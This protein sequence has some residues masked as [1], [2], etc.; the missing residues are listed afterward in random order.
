M[1]KKKEAEQRNY[2]TY[3]KHFNK[4][5]GIAINRFEWVGLPK[6]IPEDFI[7]KTLIDKGKVV[8]VKDNMLDIMAYYVN[9]NGRINHYGYS[10]KITANGLEYN[11]PFKADEVV[12]CYN[13]KSKLGIRDVIEGECQRLAE[14]D[15]TIDTNIAGQ[16]TPFI[17]KCDDKTLLTLKIAYENIQT[18]T[19]VIFVDKNIN[20]SEVEVFQTPS[21]FVADKLVDIKHTIE[22][23]L[24]TMLGIDNTNID[25]KERVNTDE[26]K[27]NDEYIEN[28][29]QTMFSER[30]KCCK[31]LKEL[32]GLDVSIKVR[33]VCNAD[34][35]NTTTNRE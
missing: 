3:L 17:V 27:A 23:E 13:N 24:L 34:S 29:F 16:K 12:I 5:Y 28:N 33:G 9:D 32:Y 14:I 15:R 18:N 8:F 1:N 31:L 11:K 21:P 7:E 30:V 26:V 10:D 20:L 2:S 6:S 25:K 22:N 35:D 4:F 19:P